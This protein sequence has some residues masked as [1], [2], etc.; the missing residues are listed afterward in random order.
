MIKFL[1]YL[2]LSLATVCNAY[3]L[4]LFGYQLHSDIYQ[5]AGDGEITYNKK[6]FVYD[7]LSSIRQKI[8]APARKKKRNN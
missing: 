5:Y 1:L 6:S 7:F 4:D 2:S 8:N 3:T